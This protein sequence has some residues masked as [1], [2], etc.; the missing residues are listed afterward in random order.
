MSGGNITTS[1]TGGTSNNYTWSG[2]PGLSSTSGSTV[3]ITPPTTPGTSWCPNNSSD[4]LSIIVPS[5]ITFS[6]VA[7][8]PCVANAYSVSGTLQTAT[9]PTTGNLV[10]EDYNG[11]QTIIALAPFSGTSFPFNLTGLDADGSNCTLTAFFTA[12]NCPETTS[13]IAPAPCTG[14]GNVTI[15]YAANSVNTGC[16]TSVGSISLVGAGGT[17]PYSYSIDNGFTFVSSGTF[18]TLPA[19]TYTVV[20]CGER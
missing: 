8:E 15:T 5:P 7:T 2:D 16:G 20:M 17:A 6:N 4:V 13:F 11:N 19:G 9:T 14:C 12:T 10:L 1:V 3:T 18:N